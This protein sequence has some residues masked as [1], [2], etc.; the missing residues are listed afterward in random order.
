MIPDSRPRYVLENHEDEVYHE[1]RLD[2]R[3]TEP[4]YYAFLDRSW[5]FNRA[6]RWLDAPGDTLVCYSAGGD[7]P[8]TGGA[9]V[10]EW[11]SDP[12][13]RT[14][15]V[16][17]RYTR[18][19][20]YSA[21]RRDC[22]VLPGLQFN[23]E[24]HPTVRLEVMDATT[25]WQF[26]VLVK[27]RSG[28]PL[29][30]GPWGNGP[31]T[32]EFDL[33]AALRGRGYGSCLHFAEL[34]FVVGLWSPDPS[35][36][37]AVRFRL[38]LEGA[39]ALLP[40]LPVIRARATAEREGVPLSAL[41]LD[42]AGGRPGRTDVE[43]IAQS[44]EASCALREEEGLWSGRLP[45]LPAGEHTVRLRARGSIS[46][47]TDLSVRITDGEFLGYDAGVH[48]LTRDGVPTG[49]LSGSF[50]GL[51]YARQVGQ[52][53][54]SLVQGQA[55]FDAWDRAQPPGEHWHYWEAL[56]ERELDE[57]FGF[58]RVNGWHLLHL[59]QH[60]GLWKK[61]DAG[62]RIGPHGAEQVALY[63][64]VAA[65][66]G[67]SVIQALSHYPYGGDYT[68]PYRRYLE[69]GFQPDDW[70]DIE[71]PFTER[72]HGYLGDYITLFREETAVAFLTASGEGDRTAGP[73][74]VNA[75][76]RFLQERD[77]H[78][79]FLSEPIGRMDRLP[80]EHCAGW[81]QP[82]FGSRLYWI[83]ETFEPEVD[84]G[85]EFKLM[86][87]GPVFMAE[88]S[89]PCPHLYAEFTGKPRTW[90][91]TEEYRLRVR[92]SLYLGLVH[93]IP[94]L[95]T[96]EE[97][98][99][100]DEHRLLDLIRRQVDWS[101][102]FME[103]P[104]ALRVDETCVRKR[105]AV[106]HQYE[107]VFSALPLTTRYLSPDEPVPEGTSFVIDAREA[108]V[109]PAFATD[110]APIPDSVRHGMPLRIAPGFRASYTWSQDRR[111]LLA[112][113][114]NCTAHLECEYV[115]GGRFHRL[116]RPARLHIALQ[117]LPEMRL[118]ARIY[119]LAAKTLV[120]EETFSGE[121]RFDGGWTAADFFV[122]VTKADEG[123]RKCQDPDARDPQRAGPA[124]RD[125]AGGAGLRGAEE[126]RGGYG[127]G[128]FSGGAARPLPR[129]ED[130]PAGRAAE[131]YP[132]VV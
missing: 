83:G 28:P 87:M 114:Y 71:R 72:F 48:L 79:L 24:Q 89:W 15:H 125:R 46:A 22:A 102:T 6:M 60:W 57:R 59:C 18:F 84:L 21:R 51:A 85:I 7:L 106:L 38:W 78:H 47:E 77:P 25:D 31:G 41:I 8:L 118:R 111:T 100:E 90:C 17:D 16:D 112:Y 33:R 76:I 91:G 74:R 67:L 32:L 44:G 88:G 4:E 36:E 70:R 55:A 127:D 66:H 56:T 11:F 43:L 98:L 105:R 110:G 42:E 81:E 82:L 29:M 131:A 80:H 128:P 2:E 1:L 9:C 5:V 115:L 86:R 92:D 68:P 19:V 20:R 113:V 104:V 50:Q 96:W 103:A 58:L 122:L 124:V 73:A 97:Q 40:C 132:A 3:A 123:D 52:P 35:S 93:R 27:G 95:L 37:D 117:H 108:F 10:S 53:D 34:F 45:P 107:D 61:L 121:L 23:V 130:G 120:C 116:P 62:G 64:R 75:T 14:E 12:V 101:Q 63:Y 119:D 54:E 65:R 99:T 94:I 126:I 49:P 69:A 30:A 26:C 39:P 129:G 13:N 109:P